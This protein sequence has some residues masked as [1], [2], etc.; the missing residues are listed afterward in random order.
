MEKSKKALIG[1]LLTSI[2][3]FL[4]A[5]YINVQAQSCD[6]DALVPVK[7]GQRGN[8]VKNAQLCLI[9]AGYDIPSGATGHYGAQ[10]RNA[11]KKFYADWYGA[12]NGNSLGPKGVAELKSRLAGAAKPSAPQPTTGGVSQDQLQQ[13]LNLLSQGK[14]NEAL[15]LLLSLL[16]QKQATTTAT[17]TT[18]QQPAA[19]EEGFLT[20]E[21]DP[22]VGVVTLREGETGK[23]VGIRFRAD[24]GAVT[25]KSIF[26]RWTGNTAPYRVISHLALKDS[27]GNVLYEA[28][29]GPSTFLQDSNLNY[30]LPISGLNVQVPKNGYNSVF[31]EVTV[32]GTLPSGATASFQ[33]KKDDVRGV[34]GAGVDRFGPSD[35]LS[36]DI[37]L[38]VSIAGSAYF[39]GARNINSPLEGYITADDVTTGKANQKLV[40]KFD[41]TAKND[42]LRL[43]QITGSVSNTSTVSAVYL[44]QG[45]ITLDSQTPDKNGTFTFNL[46]PSNFIINKDQ[47]VTFDILVDLAG[48]SSTT[49][50]TFTVNV[51]TTTGQNSLGDLR[52]N[53]INLTS[54]VRHYMN[55]APTFTVVSK[56]INVT[57]DQS[58]STTTVTNAEFK[59]DITAV[60]GDVYI[61]TT[62]VAKI[63]LETASGITSTAVVGPSLVMQGSTTINPESSGYYRIP[64]G[65]TYTFTFLTSGQTFGGVQS[66]R[67][68]LSSIQ[69]IPVNSSNTSIT[70]SFLG[71]NSNFWTNYVS[72]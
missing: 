32:V 40:Y 67:A 64:E 27:S 14:T 46:V 13:V 51:A 55:V 34:D 61:S 23:V 62:S 11:V 2:L 24:N 1:L 5:P 39:I 7:Y 57:K 33:V 8:A 60:G 59:I 12:W 10:T 15:A 28:N 66:V 6:P 22:S 65:S 4:V 3:V 44:R 69:W 53:Y 71:S 56:Q 16:G 31:V 29:V 25:V 43:T 68:K 50:A 19:A 30:Y 26:L 52:S 63:T 45:S 17:T 48:G 35:E 58:N 9:E 21:K 54:E 70:A 38:Q 49:E 42:N 36:W 20:V 41:L 18:P 47:T 72:P 37:S